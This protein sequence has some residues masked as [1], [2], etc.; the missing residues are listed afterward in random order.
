MVDK[1]VMKLHREINDVNHYKNL[2]LNL[3]EHLFVQLVNLYNRIDLYQ[4]YVELSKKKIRSIIAENY[5]IQT[6]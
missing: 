4:I 3:L 1:N 5:D 2:L 6:L